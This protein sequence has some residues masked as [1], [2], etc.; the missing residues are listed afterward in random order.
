VGVIPKVQYRRLGQHKANAIT[1]LIMDGRGKGG[2]FPLRLGED[3]VGA[4]DVHRLDSRV[5]R[6]QGVGK[7]GKWGKWV[8]GKRYVD[9]RLE[10]R[11]SGGQGSGSKE[12][13][14]VG[15]VEDREGREGNWESW[16]N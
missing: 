7:D 13:R 4:G 12:G 11:K 8:I 2:K 3:A 16:G 5:V 9:W 6:G 10:S 1:G 15:E 14:S